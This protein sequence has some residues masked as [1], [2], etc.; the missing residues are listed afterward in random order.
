MERLFI[1]RQVKPPDTLTEVSSLRSGTPKA[2]VTGS[3]LLPV[4]TRAGTSSS[5][6]SRTNCV[7]T[8]LNQSWLSDG[9]LNPVL[10]AAR[11]AKPSTISKRAAIFP[12]KVFPKSL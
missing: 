3:W 6:A 1:G 7:L 8:L 12:L 5:I 9:A 11:S 2:L 4:R 10:T